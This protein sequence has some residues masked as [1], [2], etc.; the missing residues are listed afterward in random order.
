MSEEA[1]LYSLW[2]EVHAGR[3]SRWQKVLANEL[4]NEDYICAAITMRWLQRAGVRPRIS[5]AQAAVLML[6]NWEECELQAVNW[7]EVDYE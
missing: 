1:N 6:E 5:Y 7:S 2:G 4:D 3:I